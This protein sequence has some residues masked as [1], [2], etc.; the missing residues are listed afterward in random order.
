[1]LGTD[2]HILSN[3]HQQGRLIIAPCWNVCGYLEKQR[4][5]S[6]WGIM[7]SIFLS[8]PMRLGPQ[9]QGIMS[10]WYLTSELLSGVCLCFS[11]KFWF[12]R[13]C[14]LS[15]HQNI[16]TLRQT[17]IWTWIDSTINIIGIKLF[18]KSLCFLNIESLQVLWR[19]VGRISRDPMVY[20]L[21][22]SLASSRLDVFPSLGCFANGQSS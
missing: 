9:K 20:S 2:T 11:F 5:A 10:S 22:C 17:S 21:T 18:P 6:I 13:S 14:Y 12:G 3:Q 19:K 8:F 4:H 15:T 7:Q 16:A 1:M